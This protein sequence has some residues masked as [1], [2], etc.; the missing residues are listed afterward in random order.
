MN[1]LSVTIHLEASSVPAWE[2]I[3]VTGLT[4]QVN[5]K[6]A[7]VYFVFFSLLV[8]RRVLTIC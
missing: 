1:M 5:D 2:D 7:N 6:P 3:S 4:V 8:D